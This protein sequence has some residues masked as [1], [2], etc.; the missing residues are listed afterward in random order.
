MPDWLQAFAR[1]QPFTHVVN[2]MRALTQGGPMAHSVTM[3][4]VWI[5]GITLVCASLAVHRYR[6]G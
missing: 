3:S 1:N 4:L 6:T 5:A 2:S